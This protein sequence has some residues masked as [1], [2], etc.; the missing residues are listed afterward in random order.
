MKFLSLVLVFCLL[1][2]VGTFAKSLESFYGMTEHPGKCVY[3]D[4]IIA[5]G[6]TAKPKGKCQRFSCGEELV[7]HIQSCD[8]RYIILEPPCWW[9]D[10][11]NPDLDY[12][13][14]CM[15]K[16]ICPETDDTTDVYN[17]LC[18]LT[19]CQFQFISPP[20]FDCIKMKVLVIALV[21]AFCTTAFSYEM[22]GFFKEDAHP[23]KC[24][25]K[26]LIL[27]AGE[28][29][30]P[31]SECVRLLCGDNSFGTIQG[32]GTQAAA[33]PCKLGDY[34]NRDGKYPECCKR[35]VVCP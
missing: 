7:G 19:I 16:I 18:S 13:S 20:S 11:E 2:V 15:R 27:S 32:C 35:H 28:E 23:G 1:S 14:C 9:G 22:S 8:Y 34:V 5:P 31:K 30:Y 12:P 4:L 17:G 10:I 25:Y 21:L 29:G 3:E 6:E 33:P 24:V 26:D